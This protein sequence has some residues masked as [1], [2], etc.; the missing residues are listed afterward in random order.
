[1]GD[2]K[3]E[4]ARRYESLSNARLQEILQAGTYTAQAIEVALDELRSRGVDVPAADSGERSDATEADDLDSISE[5]KPGVDLVTVYRSDNPF[6]ANVIANLLDAEGIFAH[7]WG[8]NLG[9]ANIIW[10]A[11]AGGMRVQVREDQLA[12]AKEVVAKFERG[13]YRL[14]EE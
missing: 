10:S 11:A 12:Q 9:V 1:V 13:E 14:E 4:L 2:T 5:V 6:T 8:Q 3:E 7:V